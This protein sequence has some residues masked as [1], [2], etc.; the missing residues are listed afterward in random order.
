MQTADLDPC[1]KEIAF[2]GET[3]WRETLVSV[4]QPPTDCSGEW[5]RKPLEAVAYIVVLNSEKGA[6]KG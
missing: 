2:V 3:Y 1:A 4:V 6:K 5:M